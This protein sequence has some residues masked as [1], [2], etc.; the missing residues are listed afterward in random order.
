[1]ILATLSSC[2]IYFVPKDSQDSLD[3]KILALS[4]RIDSVNRWN[5]S[6]IHRDVA[7]SLL[8]TLFQAQPNTVRF[9]INVAAYA[10]LLTSVALLPYLF[11]PFRDPLN[12]SLFGYQRFF[13]MGFFI[14]AMMF[15]V[16]SMAV[17]ITLLTLGA[18]IRF[19]LIYVII[20]GVDA[21]VST[22]MISALFV[23]LEMTRG[24]LLALYHGEAITDRWIAFSQPFQALYYILSHPASVFDAFKAEYYTA[25]KYTTYL[26]SVAAMICAVLPLFVHTLAAIFIVISSI[27][28]DVMKRATSYVLRRANEQKTFKLLAF[29]FAAPAAFMKIAEQVGF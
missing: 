16:L 11:I 22:V 14:P 15:A 20:L 6:T 10:A 17:T 4:T 26:L 13:L 7:F 21:L 27:F 12:V 2:C 9:Y 5:F 28:H 19:G 3:E 29:V 24:Y 18:R 8:A 23:N 25:S 1:L